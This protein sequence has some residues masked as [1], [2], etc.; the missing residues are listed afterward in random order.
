MPI[1]PVIAC[2]DLEGVLVP[3]IWINVAEKT[4]IPE[5]RLT[6]RDEP[7]YDVLMKRRLKIL[8]EHRLTLKDIQGVIATMAPLDGAK[9]FLVWLRACCQVIIL[10]DTFEQFAAPLLKQLDYPTLFCNTL[11]VAQDGRI[12]NYHLRL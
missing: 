3:E 11:E 9:D 7:N 10:S 12:V 5:L 1:K 2:L 4:K 6:T 8:E